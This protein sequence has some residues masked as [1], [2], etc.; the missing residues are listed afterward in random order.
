M[1]A[2]LWQELYKLRHQRAIWLFTAF[3]II[4][5]LLMASY[6]LRYP[7]LLAGTDAFTNSYYGFIPILFFSIANGSTYLTN[8]RQSGTLRALLYRSYSR[9]K[10]LVS[11]WLALLILSS[12]LYLLCTT[13]SFIIKLT[14]FNHITMTSHLWQTLGL[15]TLEQGLTLLFLM[16]LVLLLGTLFTSSTPAIITGVVSYFIIT[17]FSQLNF[18]L[19]AK[20][21]W[22]K[23]N[24]FN[25]F[26][27]GAQI[28]NHHLQQ[29]TELNLFAISIG[30]LGYLI[31]LLS[32]AAFSF[33]RRN[34]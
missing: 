33:Q 25:M 9:T 12:Y 4:F 19:I 29:L 3:L 32:L 30:Y 14:L 5:Q 2:L 17:I 8:E 6:A 31:L 21:H 11:K 20:F 1:L 26:N 16:S 24:P 18:I 27:L 15:S 34:V 7:Q 10:V 28:E 23:W 22:L 13:I